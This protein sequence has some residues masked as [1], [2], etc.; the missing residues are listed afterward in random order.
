MAV[1]DSI[2]TLDR[3]L[4][5]EQMHDLMRTLFP[6]CRSITGA[7]VRQT[8]EHVAELTDLHVTEVPTG[9]PVLDWVVPKEWAVRDAYVAAADG[10]RIIDFRQ[11]NLH[12]LNYSAPFRGTLTYEELLPRL[13][14][15]PDR[16]TLTPYRTSYY[17]E[18][19]GFC[20]PHEWLSR[21]S[22]DDTY[23][24]VVDTTLADGSL[25][26]GEIVVP[27]SVADEVLVSCHVCHP[28][29]CNDNLSGIVVAT[30]LAQLIAATD[31]RFT[32]RFVFVPGT[33][34]SIAWLAGNE[35]AVARVKHGLVLTGVG[36]QGAPTYKR[37]R[38]GDADIDR[39]MCLALKHSGRDHGVRDFS[40]WGYDERQ[41]CSPGY[42]LPVG[43]LMRTPHGEYPEY[44]TSADDLQFVSPA[45]LA[46]SLALCLD[47]FDVLERNGSYRNTNPKGEPQLG[48]R[49]IYGAIG[50]SSNKRLDELAL[51]WLLNLS[52]GNNSLIDVAE[53]SGIAFSVVAG[54]AQVLQHYELLV[55][56]DA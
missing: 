9:T 56:C 6:L 14:T 28:S 25:S 15:L 52:D 44:H 2:G 1:H 49:G 13:F 8:L 5:G 30:E 41:Y 45:S 37:S 17:A 12:L 18:N 11:S 40:P 3:A 54:A 47:A 34:G 42:N 48:R 31:H 33:V 21:F 27:G 4:L 22:P 35:D 29:L 55:P 19:W 7:G 20:L 51:L 46:D 43:C 38:I 10:T 26:Y 16:P 50:G 39:A 53:K 23:D 24:V 36:D 32:Y